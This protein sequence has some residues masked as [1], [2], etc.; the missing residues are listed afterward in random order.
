MTPDFWLG[1]TVLL[2]GHT[3]FKGAWL[4]LWLKSVGA[5]VIGFSLERPSQPCLFDLAGVGIDVHD[6]EGDVQ[7]FD[8][9]N[10]AV[11]E[12]APDIVIHMAAQSLVRRSY[13]APLE[14]FATN[15]MGTANLL[16]AV[17]ANPGARV[18]LVVT[19][20]KCY[21]N[22]EHNAAFNETDAMGGHDPYSSS[23]GCAELVTAAWRQSF[24]S[25]QSAPG[26]AS[27]RAGNVI[28]GGDFAEDRIV[29]DIVNAFQAGRKVELRHPDAIR[30]WQ[31]VLEPLNGYL[32]LAERLWSD[33]MAFASGWNFGPR[34]EDVRPVAWLA[35]ALAARWGELA[36][37]EFDAT[38]HP[39]EAT[40]LTLDCSK[41]QRLLKWQ[42]ALPLDE[43]LDWIVEWYRTYFS[44]GDVRSVTL[45]QIEQFQSRVCD[46]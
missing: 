3:G 22:R 39:H 26:V 2:T 29:P 12:H 15:V 11:A 37:W 7:Q 44:G 40:H 5:N 27:A 42:P 36:G 13:R 19:S 24:F 9:L 46:V 25:T 28:G 41:A 14:T 32:D 18:V 20:D 16:E 45:H 35:N 6:M 30:P 34:E 43:T 1:K 17:R 8:A 10:A 23:K 33:P 4:S 31:F 38:H 21:E